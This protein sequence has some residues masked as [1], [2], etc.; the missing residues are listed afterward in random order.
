MDEAALADKG[1]PARDISSLFGRIFSDQ[2]EKRKIVPIK[3]RASWR[4]GFPALERLRRRTLR[5]CEQEM[6]D[7]RKPLPLTVLA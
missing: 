3:S 6:D 2:G 4:A 7:N 5:P 1:K